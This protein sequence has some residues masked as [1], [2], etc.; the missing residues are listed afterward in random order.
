M[1]NGSSRTIAAM[2][3]ASRPTTCRG[4]GLRSVNA[5]RM[6]SA[7]ADRPDHDNACLAA[8]S[9][10]GEQR[11]QHDLGDEQLPDQIDLQL[12]P[13]HLNR[14]ILQRAG[15]GRSSVVHQPHQ[16]TG[17]GDCRS[18]RSDRV[19]VLQIHQHGTN[20]ITMLSRQSVGVSLAAHRRPHHNAV[21][22][23]RGDS[24]RTYPR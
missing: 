3:L 8:L 5:D 9:Y 1:R 23:Q 20:G 6:T 12:T 13:E 14:Q 17:G 16:R 18:G 24:S 15:Q 21:P 19:S 22:D 10:R 7:T 4:G 2:I 11:G